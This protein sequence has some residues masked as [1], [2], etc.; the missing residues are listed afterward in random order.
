MWLR[1]GRA[2]TSL[3]ADRACRLVEPSDEPYAG[4]GSGRLHHRLGVVGRG[5]V[6]ALVGGGDAAETRSSRRCRSAGPCSRPVGRV[7]HPGDQGGAVGAEDRLRGLDLDL[8]AQR[9]RRPSPARARSRASTIASTWSTEVTLGR[10]T[11]KPSG[12][13]AAA[14]P[15]TAPGCGCR[16]RRVDAL[17]ALE[18]DAVEGRPRRRLDRLPQRRGGRRGG[19]VLLVVGADA[20]AVLEVDPQVLDRLVVELARAPRSSSVLVAAD[21]VEEVG[22]PADHAALGGR[23]RTS[24]TVSRREPVG[25]DIDGVH[26]LATRR[27]PP[28]SPRRAPRR[29]RPECWSRSAIRPAMSIL[30]P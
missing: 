26:R 14:P 27:R 16:A 13:C 3:V 25:R 1:P 2:R 8:E 7:D 22:G 15:G 20:V 10:V 12:I 6:E 30:E 11:T 28:G 29:P 17:E 4:A 24:W 18:P 21:H 23:G 5:V 9:R 19:R